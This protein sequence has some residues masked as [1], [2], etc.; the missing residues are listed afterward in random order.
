MQGCPRNALWVTVSLTP[1][2]GTLGHDC[3][4]DFQGDCNLSSYPDVAM[5]CIAMYETVCMFLNLYE[6]QTKLLVPFHAMRKLRSFA[7]G[8]EE[9]SQT[10]RR[11]MLNRAIGFW[12]HPLSEGFRH[13]PQQGQAMPSRSKIKNQYHNNFAGYSYIYII[14]IILYY[15]IYILY[16][17]IIIYIIYILLLYIYYIYIC[18]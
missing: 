10:L 16:I 3:F 14:Y 18:H 7:I 1:A 11:L 5:L 13:T 4:P 17:Y 2:S 8:C 9:R 12:G 15:I 6:Q